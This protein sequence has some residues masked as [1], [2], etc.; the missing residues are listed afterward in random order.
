MTS[1]R[2]LKSTLLSVSVAVTLSVGVAGFAD[3]AGAFGGGEQGSLLIHGPGSVFAAGGGSIHS[4]TTASGGAAS[5]PFEVK[6]T[7]TSTSQYN[8]MVADLGND[9]L[10]CP[11]ATYTVTAGSLVVTKLAQGPNGYFTAGIDPG[12]TALF[13]LKVTTPAGAPAG[14]VYQQVIELNDTA[15]NMLD[16]VFAMVNVTATTGTSDS[17]QFV[18]GAGGQKPTGNGTNVTAWVT[19]P[20]AKVGAKST[21]TV[22]LENDSAATSQ[23]GYTLTDATDCPGHFVAS[24]KQGTVDVTAAALGAGYLTAPL[25][26]GRSVLLTVTVT[27]AS[28]PLPECVFKYGFFDSAAFTTDDYQLTYLI[29][30]AVP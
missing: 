27:Y 12:K 7:G 8:L 19:D 20:T 3:S 10:G 30:P 5:F 2:T 23:I 13:T 29:V 17:D 6:N 18:T 15:G 26:H 4:I 21:F 24:V 22:K 28:V 11:A 9:C 14:R 1:T 25:A 16:Y